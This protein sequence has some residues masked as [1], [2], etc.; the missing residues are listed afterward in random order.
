MTETLTGTLIEVKRQ[1][2]SGFMIGQIEPS[3]KVLGILSNPV[4]GDKLEFHGRWENHPRYGK[5][6]NFDLAVTVTPRTKHDM[7]EFLSQ[8]KHIGPVRGCAIMDRF[9]DDIFEILDFDP[10]RLTS[11]S[12]ITDKR[13]QTIIEEWNRIK[14][15]KDTIF[16]LNGLG[17]NSRQ[18]ALIMD[19]YKE[20]T[21]EMVKENPYRMIDDIKGFSFKLVDGFAKKLG[22]TNDSPLRANAAV[23]YI[24]KSATESQQHTYLPEGKIIDIDTIYFHVSG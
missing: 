14:A 22:F 17:C 11:I 24:L 15:D 10:R 21:I 23:V 16:F 2:G 6:F 13:V 19:A 20:K 7:L 3:I 4:I 1:F 12:G 5:Q 18:R 9:G 8:L